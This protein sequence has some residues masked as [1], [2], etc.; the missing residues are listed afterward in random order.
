MKNLFH[1]HFSSR[2][3]SKNDFRIESII[4]ETFSITHFSDPWTHFGFCFPEVIS[5]KQ[6]SQ[7]TSTY[8][9]PLT[10]NEYPKA[11]ASYLHPRRR[12][13]RSVPCTTHHHACQRHYAPPN[14]LP[15]PLLPFNILRR[16]F[17]VLWKIDGVQEAN[18]GGTR[19]NYLN[20]S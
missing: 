15:T 20:L 1:N 13:R 6:F 17:V 14:N 3:L 7:T 8:F 2:A 5:R 16:V 11:K 12:C 10:P 18:V 9:A 19:S 4:M